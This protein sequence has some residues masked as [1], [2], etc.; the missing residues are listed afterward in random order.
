MA[1]QPVLGVG[2]GTARVVPVWG[3]FGRIEAICS[4]H[5][6]ISPPIVST[7]AV[8]AQSPLTSIERR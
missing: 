4:A 5:H 8:S 3:D 2:I 7:W 6:T 1:V